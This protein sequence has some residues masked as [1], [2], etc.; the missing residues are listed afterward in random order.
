MNKR[1]PLKT[2]E[3]AANLNG[4]GRGRG[5]RRTTSKV[6]IN[7]QEFNE[8]VDEIKSQGFSAE[9]AADYAMLIGDTPIFQDGHVVVIKDGKVIARLKGLKFFDE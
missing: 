9:D 7:E 5:G 3:S 6:M 1:L 2:T 4:A 8:L